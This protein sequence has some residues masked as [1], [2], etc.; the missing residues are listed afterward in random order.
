VIISSI[1]GLLISP[2]MSVIFPILVFSVVIIQIIFDIRVI[3]LV[4][5]RERD[6]CQEALKITKNL[7]AAQIFYKANNFSQWEDSYFF[8]RGVF[9]PVENFI[10][11]LSEKHVEQLYTE[12][13]SKA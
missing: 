8:I 10:G 12:N 4:R 2:I 5:Q 7:K 9:R 1:A 11:E 13:H 3:A 6:V